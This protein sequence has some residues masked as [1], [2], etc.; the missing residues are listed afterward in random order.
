MRKA[1]PCPARARVGHGPHGVGDPAH[2]RKHLAREP[3]DPRVLQI[4]SPMQGCWSAAGSQKAHA[5]DARAWEVRQPRS[6]EEGPEQS[7]E[8]GG[9]G[10]GSAASS[11]AQVCDPAPKD[12]M[13]GHGMPEG[14]RL[15]EFLAALSLATDLGMG[16]PLEQ[17]LCTCLLALALGER[18]G[19]GADDLSDVYYVALLR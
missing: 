11:N 3:G 14:L 1:T 2:A 18:M 7:P 5:A 6:A 8:A 16:Q 13:Y 10:A 15:A 12:G 17:A 4:A 19:L 9:G